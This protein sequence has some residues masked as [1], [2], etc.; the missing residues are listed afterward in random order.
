MASVAQPVPITCP[1]HSR[2]VPDLCFGDQTPRGCFLLSACLDGK[3]MLRDAKTGDWIGTFEGH[4][5]AIWCAR[6]DGDCS[7]VATASADFTVKL[8]DGFTGDEVHEY[9]HN[10][11]VKAVEFTSDSKNIISGGQEKKLRLWDVSRNDEPVSIADANAKIHTI[12][13]TKKD[14]NVILT[15]SADLTG[16]NV[17]DLR[18]FKIERT[19][20]TPDRVT[21]MQCRKDQGTLVASSGRFIQTFDVDRNFDQRHR[22]NIPVNESSKGPL[23]CASIFPDIEKN[24]QVVATYEEQHHVH[25]YDLKTGEELERFRG[26]HGPA[27]TVDVA[28]D[29]LSI[30]SGSGDSTIRLWEIKPRGK[31]TAPSSANG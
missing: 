18:T 15:S 23:N 24:P 1:G 2:G 19:L 4:K 25:I 31:P 30:A 3:P 29:G 10:H 27:N 6:F 17:W 16:I 8:W 11:I 20:V 21:S 7:H 14:P 28:C 5:G 9:V 12:C 26:H 13:V 22:I